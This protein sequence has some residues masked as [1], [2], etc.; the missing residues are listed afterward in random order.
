[1]QDKQIDELQARIA[2]LEE[3]NRE[4]EAANNTADSPAEKS[5]VSRDSRAKGRVRSITAFLLIAVSVILAPISVMGAWARVQLVDTDSFVQTFAP[6]ATEPE[7]QSFVAAQAV[8]GIEQNVDIDEL[9]GELFAT[10]AEL[11]MPPRAESALVLLEGYTAQGVRALIDVGANR[12]VQSPQFAALWT[13]TLQ[14]THSRS[15]ALLEGNPEALIQL[16]DEGLISLDLSLVISSIRQYMAD[17]GVALA[18]AIPEVEWSVPL[19]QSDSLALVRMVYNL[20]DQVGYWLPWLMI[21]LLAAGVLTSR[22]RM[23]T[24]AWSG[25]SVATSLGLLAAGL[26]VGR[27]FFVTQ[28]SASLM[29]APTAYVVFDQ[30]TALMWSTLLALIFLSVFVAI[31]AWIAGSS[32]SARNVRGTADRISS[33]I[34]QELAVRGIRAGA[35]GRFVGRWYVALV[36]ATVMICVLVLFVR[37]PIT[38]GGV[39]ATLMIVLAAILLLLVIRTPEEHPGTPQLQE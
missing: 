31:G 30:L 1:M 37:Q 16:S 17:N 26:G 8:R 7:V 19:L 3:R 20:T 36:I 32:D 25:V 6:L 11:D 22:N 5:S 33:S 29:P 9:V 15:V 27:Q 23:R 18:S 28:V 24:L 14:R 2:Q 21:V 34:H 13:Q 39:I 38:L 4:L 12:L 35:I 10:V